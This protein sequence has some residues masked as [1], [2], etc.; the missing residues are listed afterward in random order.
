MPRE[1][2]FCVKYTT[3]QEVVQWR[4]QNRRARWLGKSVD[5]IA[6]EYD[7]TQAGVYAAL[8]YYFDHRAEIE[9]SL[10]EGA[11]FVKALRRRTPSK[12][13]GKLRGRKGDGAGR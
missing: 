3:A 5:E 2:S 10:K 6:A 13:R 7:L 8:A 11:A 4:I 9:R 12:V 1:W